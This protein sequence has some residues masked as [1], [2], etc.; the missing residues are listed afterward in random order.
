MRC[1]ASDAL[2]RIRLGGPFSNKALLG[3][4]WAD[5]RLGNFQ[6]ALEHWMRLRERD[7]FLMH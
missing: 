4:G 3:L 2:Q 6:S 1:S 5:A 7:L